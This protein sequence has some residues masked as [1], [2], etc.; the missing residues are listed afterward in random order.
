MV[1][2]MAVP[3][4]LD[5]GVKCDVGDGTERGN[6]MGFLSQHSAQLL[7]KLSDN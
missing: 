2:G 6:T 4:Y 5:C 3:C 7:S 1:E